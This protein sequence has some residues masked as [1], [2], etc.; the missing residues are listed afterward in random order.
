MFDIKKI[1]V[2]KIEEFAKA[3]EAV[4]SAEEAVA[5]AGFEIRAVTEKGDLQ[6][7]IDDLKKIAEDEV[8][9]EAKDSQP[10]TSGSVE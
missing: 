10:G 6:L 4:K 3:S 1:R 7:T 8:K 9:D 2:T 5:G